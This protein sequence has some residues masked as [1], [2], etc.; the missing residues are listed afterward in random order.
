[1]NKKNKVQVFKEF[2]RKVKDKV[3]KPA[4][5][6]NM[7]NNEVDRAVDMLVAH[8][9]NEELRQIVEFLEDHTEV[10]HLNLS[11]RKTFKVKDI[12]NL[13]AGIKPKHSRRGI[14]M[15]GKRALQVI[16]SVCKNGEYAWINGTLTLF[17]KP[18]I[19]LST[20]ETQDAFIYMNKRSIRK[21]TYNQRYI[22]P[23][24]DEMTE[25][26]KGFNIVVD[27]CIIKR[28]S[29]ATMKLPCLVI[30]GL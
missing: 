19:I 22:K 14:F 11:K 8:R 15:I 21:N 23:I 24:N 18:V 20:L 28:N 7:V 2:A 9:Q 13:M 1:M 12:E 5:Q 10:A 25:F 27:I 17:N 4:L 26:E 29:V 6:E 16:E 3:S 30:E